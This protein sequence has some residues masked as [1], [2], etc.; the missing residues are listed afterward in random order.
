MSTARVVLRLTDVVKAFPGVMALKGVSLEVTEGE[1]HALVGENGAG[2]STLMA[3]AAGSLLP[4]RGSVEIGGHVME[5]PSP[6]AAQAL[7]IAVVYQH[8]SILED[9]T[10][11]ETMVLAMPPGRRPSLLRAGPWARRQLAVVGAASIDPST[12]VSD[13]SVADRQLVEIAKALAL[14]PKVLVLDEPTESLT[15]VESAL[16]FDQVR[17]I[18][19]AGTAVVYISHRL[20]EVQRIADRITVLR[21]GETRGT[22]AAASVSEDEILRLIIG[23]AVDQAFP[24][25]GDLAGESEPLLSVRGLSGPRFHDVDLDVR[26]GEIVGLAGVEGN[27]QREFLRA[28]AGLSRASGSVALAG[29]RVG[30]GDP[31]RV[32]RAGIVH[33]PGDRHA[34]GLLLPLSVREN[35]SLLALASVARGG[36]VQRRREAEMVAG[37]IRQ[38]DVRTPGME[39]PISALSGG[40]QQKVLFARSLLA[41]PALLLAD[42]PTRGVDANARLEL[43][44]VLRRVAQA[45]QAVIVVSSDVVELQGLCDRVIVFSRGQAVRTLTGGDISE[46]NITG[47]AITSDTQRAAHATS[48]RSRMQQWRRFGAGDYLPTA[49]LAVLIGALTLYTA[50]SNDFFLTK[51][52]FVGMLL[53]GS[54]LGFIAIGQLIVLLTGGIDL[55]VGPLTGLVVVVM[56]FFAGQ[57]QSDARFVLGILAVIGTAL[58]VGLTNAALVRVVRLA[59]VIA[60]LATYIVLQG[61][62]LLLRETPGGYYRAGVTSTI[63]TTIGWVPVAFLVVAGMALACEGMLRFT[64]FGLALRAVGSDAVR[65]H[66]LG[67]HVTITQVS[68]YVLCSLFTA[69]GGI[70]LASQIAIGDPS[71]GLN[72]TLT[73]ITAVVLGG[74][75]IFGGRGS[76]IGALFGA[77]LIQEIV[78]STT[79]LQIGTEW[80]YYLPGILILA[81]AGVYSRTRELG[82]SALAAPE[83][84]PTTASK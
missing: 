5:Q 27:G 81:G 36:V 6:A 2:K 26:P 19:A 59:P 40:N 20:P 68:A 50:Q 30:L 76:F 31:G 16:L 12:R 69:A 3:V 74:A 54:A 7:G 21:D 56:S 52:N 72:Y 62:A 33:L 15:P 29:K 37:Q 10:V 13:L 28:L 65:A 73:S 14:E 42:E 48:R 77:V 71:V 8:L 83:T 63:K 46:E 1:V 57:G 41:E 24:P 64:R 55:S 4:D 34:E 67:A 53:L 11:A 9:L 75:S 49:V 45:G 80:Q 66:R 38:L 35:T 39:T 44:Q 60:T 79:F 51:I 17:A 58:V 61:I 78:T 22:V 82:P 43:Y 70:M 25:K 84:A 47:A 32:Q 18:T 23:R